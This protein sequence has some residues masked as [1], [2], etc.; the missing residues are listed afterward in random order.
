MNRELDEIRH[1]LRERRRH[2]DELREAKAASRD[3]ALPDNVIVLWKA[4]V[5]RDRKPTVPRRG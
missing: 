5:V 3:E 4:A 1:T 2:A